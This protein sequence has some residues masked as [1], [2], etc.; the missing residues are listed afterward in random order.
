M[1]LCRK[2]P[3]MSQERDSP[4]PILWSGDGIETIN[5]T[6]WRSHWIL[7]DKKVNWLVVSTHLQN[8][9]QI[10]S[11]PQIGMNIKNIWV[12]TTQVNLPFATLDGFL[13]L[14]IIQVKES[15]IIGY[16]LSEYQ[17]IFWI[18]FL[19]KNNPTSLWLHH[20]RL[21]HC[22]IL[23]L[24][25]V[26]MFDFPCNFLNQTSKAS[27]KENT[28]H[29]KSTLTKFLASACGVSTNCFPPRVLTYKIHGHERT[30]V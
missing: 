9:C 16:L 24:I 23:C 3:G 19:K 20:I 6:L 25:W 8:I 22:L 14:G 13:P 10:G 18:T 1:L 11:F 26:N 27:K 17:G 12:A 2:D 15:S 4:E 29:N 5:P 21:I 7:R 28:K 30:F